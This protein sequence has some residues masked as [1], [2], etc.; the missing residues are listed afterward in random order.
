[1]F[2]RA[3]IGLAT[4][5]K[6][7]GALLIPALVA[8]YLI[9][10]RQA[11]SWRMLLLA[12]AISASVFVVTSPYVF[13]DWQHFHA[14][15]SLERAH[16]AAGHFGVSDTPSALFY[17]RS[18]GLRLIGIPGLMFGI[19]GAVQMLRTDRKTALAVLT[20]LCIYLAVIMTW[21][22]KADAYAMPVLPVMFWLSA[23]GLV[24]AAGYAT[25]MFR[26]WRAERVALAVLVA[27]LVVLQMTRIHNTGKLRS[28]MSAPTRR[29][30]SR[31]TFHP[32]ACI[33]GESY[34]P[35]L[36]EPFISTAEK[37]CTSRA[38]AP[39]LGTSGPSTLHRTPH[40]SVA[41][42][43]VGEFY[44]VMLYPDADYVITTGSIRDRYAKDPAKFAAQLEFYRQVDARCRK[45]REFRPGQRAHFHISDRST[46]AFGRRASVSEPRE[47]ATEGRTGREAGF[48]FSMGTKLRILPASAAGSGQLSFRARPWKRR[49][50][51]LFSAL[52]FGYA[53]CLDRLGRAEQARADL[54]GSRPASRI[55]SWP[56]LSEN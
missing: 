42:R 1:M 26:D 27:A 44:D 7:T 43:A 23:V 18:L 47:L 11:G 4:S 37:S 53:R 21:T 6:Y 51:G 40:V 45:V 55:V 10:G 20:P 49:P 22:T 9:G 14:A 16:M 33:V 48:Y 8:A 52:A 41:S 30:G 34:G 3:A 19:V 15:L 54:T 29:I 25:R 28:T 17:G 31:P 50:T 38:A 46:G 13:L 32:E 12:I 2:W 5:S 56:R 24:A 39:T 36:L 35:D